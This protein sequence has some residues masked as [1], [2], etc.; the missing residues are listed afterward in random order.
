MN[1]ELQASLYGIVFLLTA[2]ESGNDDTT[3]TEP[4][5][6]LQTGVF[7]DSKVANISYQTDSQSGRS[8][9][10][11]DSSRAPLGL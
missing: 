4:E 1:R 3:V 11:N 7:I 6:R 2:H 8:Y 5:A 10:P 9:H